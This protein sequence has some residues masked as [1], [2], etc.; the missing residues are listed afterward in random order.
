M[1]KE[2]DKD[3]TL[4]KASRVING[5]GDP[6]IEEGAVLI[7]GDKICAVGP[8]SSILPPQDAKVEEHVYKGK[9]LLPGLVDSHVHLIGIGDGRSGDD[10]VLLPDE[11]LTLQ[12]AKNAITHLHSGVTTVRDCGAKNRTTFML[13]NAVEEK[14]TQSP[15]LILS[16]RPVA[17]IGG[18]LSY[19]GIEATGDV[20]CRDAVRQLIKEGADFIKI[21]ASGGSTK[22]SFPSRPSFTI[23]EMTAICDEAHKFGKHTAAHCVST[24]A[25][26]NALDAGIDTVI[27]GSYRE[28]DGS[29]LYRPDITERLAEQGVY[30]S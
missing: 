2:T 6:V 10:L 29:Y 9:S 21:T 17:I 18:H 7:Q 26:I 3:F 28:S 11:I 25:I 5:L 27:H 4:I 22:T 23:G 19:F 8:E 24:Q 16:G 1:V 14:I 20:E 30:R 12:A 15:R 13:R